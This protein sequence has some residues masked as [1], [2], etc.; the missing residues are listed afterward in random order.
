M[1]TKYQRGSAHVVIIVLLVMALLGALG[2]VFYQNFI[3]KK[4]E[5]QPRQVQV[6]EDTTKTTQVAFQNSIYEFDHPEDWEVVTDRPHPS[7]VH[8]TVTSPSGDTEIKLSVYE[9]TGGGGYCDPNLPAKV[10][11]YNVSPVAVTKLGRSPAH[12][13]EAITDAENGGYF[14]KIGLTE[15]GGA[16]HAA[17]GDSNCTVSFVG[18]ASST[19]VEGEK[20]VQPNV[21]MNVTFPKLEDGETKKLKEMQPLKDALAGEEYQTAVQILESARKK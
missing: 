17:V 2:F 7:N 1:G 21:M 8:A 9:F 4:P 18:M 3:A 12:V 14:Y 10:R 15:E 20:V 5:P 6:E 13:V 16:T 11:F 19:I